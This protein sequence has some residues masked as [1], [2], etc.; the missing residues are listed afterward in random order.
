MTTETLTAHRRHFRG[1]RLDHFLGNAFAIAAVVTPPFV[2]GAWGLIQ[3]LVFVNGFLLLSLF[4]TPDRF[5]DPS[6]IGGKP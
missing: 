4:R 6:H 1:S 3:S 5:A 2:C